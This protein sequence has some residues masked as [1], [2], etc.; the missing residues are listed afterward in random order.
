LDL[1]CAS[2][3][4][5]QSPSPQSSF[6]VDFFFLPKRLRSCLFLA[7]AS[8]F[9]FLG[10]YSIL[11]CLLG[12]AMIFCFGSICG[13]IRCLSPHSPHP[14]TLD[15]QHCVFRGL[16]II[17]PS[18]VFLHRRPTF[19]A[20]WKP[21]PTIAPIGSFTKCYEYSKDRQREFSVVFG[22]R[23]RAADL[24]NRLLWLII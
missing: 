8:F 10:P 3:L 17:P 5:I 4:S 22:K 9:F 11:L 6:L 7:G 23:E 12:L 20:L 16:W 2:L 15:A 18:L 21:F 1:F 13:F 14:L 24:D 19:L